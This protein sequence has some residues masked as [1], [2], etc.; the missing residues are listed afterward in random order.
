MSFDPTRLYV[1]LL[2]TGLQTRDQPLYQ[3]I[4]QLIGTL[5]DISTTTNTIVSG[6]GGGG[7]TNVTQIIQSLLGDITDSFDESMIIIPSPSLI[8]PYVGVITEENDNIVTTST[9]GVVLQNTTHSTSGVPVQMSPRLRFRGHAWSTL[10]PIDAPID[11]IIEPVLISSAFSSALLRT[12]IIINGVPFISSSLDSA[13]NFIVGNNITLGA[14]GI[15]GFS[16]RQVYINSSADGQLN[17]GGAIGGVGLDFSTTAVLK[18]R[19]ISQNADAALTALNLTASSLTLGSILYA[20]TGGL[21]SQDNANHFWDGTNHRLWIGNAG[22]PSGWPVPTSKFNIYSTSDVSQVWV[23]DG[24]N[25]GVAIYAF[26]SGFLPTFKGVNAGGTM[27][28]PTA[29]PANAILF[30]MGGTGFGTA[31]VGSFKA[32]IDFLA[33]PNI[34]SGTESNTRISFYITQITT[35]TTVEIFRLGEDSVIYAF[36]PISHAKAEIDTSYQVYAP[37]TGATITMSAGQG[38]AI[39][40][41]AGTI[42]L[43]TVTL[44]STPADGQIAGMSFT[45]IVTGLTVNAPGGATVVGPPTSA[46]VNNAFRF[47]YQASSTSWFPSS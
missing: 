24:V 4:R 7:S 8:F 3:L 39:I 46:A 34:W 33:G 22:A 19:N 41:P 2:N 28:A 32:R 18:I 16:T 31:Y 1:L 27:A 29:T 44:P 40:N 21:I 14:T 37:L 10:A 45:Q 23:G 36:Y 30:R 35:T 15:L 5:S 38:R 6:G 17:L 42:A 26:G 12:T 9:D 43:L 25:A 47:Q 13:G 20:G 11:V